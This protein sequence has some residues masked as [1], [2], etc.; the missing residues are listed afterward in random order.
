MR[1]KDSKQLG[2]SNVRD[3]AT[4][5]AAPAS[6]LAHSAPTGTSDRS[7][8]VPESPLVQIDYLAARRTS[9]TEQ[10]E[11]LPNELLVTTIHDMPIAIVI[12]DCERRVRLTNTRATSI[13]D[14][15]DSFYIDPHGRLRVTSPAMERPFNQ[16]LND[17]L[18]QAEGRRSSASA[19]FLLSN[20]HFPPVS[21]SVS[22]WKFR[23]SLNSHE[24]L[25]A[26]LYLR[27]SG[28]SQLPSHEDL[29]AWFGLTKA[30]ARLACAIASG[31]TSQKYSSDQ[32]L[33]LNTVKTQFQS[34][35]DKTRVH[36]QVD[37]V[38]LL[39]SL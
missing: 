26:I 33:S 18:A 10:V 24:T 4:A 36:R 20:L 38:R 17:V 9:R 19:K 34:I 14:K 2:F 7:T 25:W 11:S 21:V 32:G 29:R 28:V 5:Y 39:S 12:L 30:E 37:L 6:R 22:T 27:D 31:T 23:D 8:V 16:F 3:R 35:L 13:V 15:R 1:E